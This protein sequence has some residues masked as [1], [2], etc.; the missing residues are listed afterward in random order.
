MYVIGTM[1]GG[2]IC[3]GVAWLAYR[4]VRSLVRDLFGCKP[5]VT[6]V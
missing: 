6:D 2:F 1:F 5:P 3:L 4:F